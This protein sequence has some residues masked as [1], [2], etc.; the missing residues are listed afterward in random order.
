MA[1]TKYG[2]SK[3]VVCLTFA[4][5]LGGKSAGLGVLGAKLSSAFY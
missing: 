2:I 1:N 4:A 5:W 3:N